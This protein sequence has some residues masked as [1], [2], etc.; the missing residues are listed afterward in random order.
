[1]SKILL[2]F[3]VLY[4]NANHL[5]EVMKSFRT[6]L[7]AI[8]LAFS[9]VTVSD[10]VAQKE[11]GVF[12]S[13]AAGVG[14]GTTGVDVNV[15]TPITSHFALRGGFSIMPNFSMSTDVDVDV[16][17]AEGMNAPSTIEMEGSIK[18]VSGELLVNYYP[19]KKG[20]FF[21]TAGAYFGG[22]TLLKISG[23][24]D[25][26]KDLVAEAGK[27]GVVIGD[28]TIPVDKNGNVS[29]GL[30]VSSFRPYVGLGFGRAVPK[31]RIGMMF[32]LGVQFHGK[33]D[34]YTDYGNVSNLLD[35]V[36]PD[37]TFS[38]VMDKLTVYPVM[39]IRLCGRIF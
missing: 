15:A 31:K 10:V 33:P 30:T 22:G 28:Y 23:H 38:K 1:M 2:S 6:L 21:L 26:L 39:K 9:G 24:S 4:F 36:D 7:C 8:S 12:N 14:I 17:A 3:V 27:A 35:E 34:V 37:D 16:E 18:R 13:L 32:E 20:A 25:Q 11:L 5:L 29:G 19:F